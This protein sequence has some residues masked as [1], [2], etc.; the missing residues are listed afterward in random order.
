MFSN[1]HRH[2][3]TLA[4][5][6][7]GSR[8]VDMPRKNLYRN[9]ILELEGSVAITDVTTPPVNYTGGAH[10][11]AFRAVKRLE[12]IANGRDTIKSI[13]MQAL[14]MKNL[15]MRGVRC[16]HVAP[17]LT[18]ATHPFGG[19]IT[20]PLASPRAVRQIDTLLNTGQ[21]STLE[22]RATFGDYLDM[23]STAPTAY[24]I[25]TFDA[26]LKVGLDETIR[27]DQ[28]PEA[29]M[30]YKELY[31]EKQI[32]GATSS[33]QILLGVGNK[34]R[35]F[36]IE[37]ESD[38]EMVDTILNK[39]TLKSGTDIYYQQEED[40]IR[41][42]NIQDLL[43]NVEALTGYYYVDFV[44]EGRLVDSLDASFLSQLEFELDVNAPGTLDYV[45]I[46]PDEIVI[47]AGQA[48]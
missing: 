26:S 47:P 12:L 24:T 22:L 4:Y 29:F 20:V 44:P 46:Y 43:G 14:A 28:R 10:E 33:F 27:L 6:A 16:L 32:S 25:A 17:G 2:V 37:C 38:G 19:V 13:P 5:V 7:N 34:Y 23:V 41:G 1:R 45:R 21:L 36:M 48:V 40:M 42:K 35:G 31:V 15:F 18:A 11:N 3:G 39:V 8:S 9:I 30:T